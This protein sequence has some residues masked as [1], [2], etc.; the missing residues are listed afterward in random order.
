MEYV[1]SDIVFEGIGYMGVPLDGV[2]YD[3]AKGI[4]PNVKGQVEVDGKMHTSLY[5]SGWLKRGPSGIIGTNRQ[6]THS[7]FFFV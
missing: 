3:S 6:F 4:L 5:V 1:R 2:P 7:F